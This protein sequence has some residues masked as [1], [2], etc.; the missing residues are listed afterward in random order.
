MFF[1]SFSQDF[2]AKKMKNVAKITYFCLAPK[3]G[4][5]KNANVALVNSGKTCFQIQ[6][7]IEKIVITPT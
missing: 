7:Y 4:S 6:S 1:T 5:T 3:R 2:D